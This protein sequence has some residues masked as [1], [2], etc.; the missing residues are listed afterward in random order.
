M[1]IHCSV[2]ECESITHAKGLCSK[3]YQRLK[4]YGNAT[5]TIYAIDVSKACSVE[6]C[7]RERT[8]GKFCEKHYRRYTKTGDPLIGGRAE[9]ADESYERMVVRNDD[10][11][12]CWGW[13]GYLDKNPNGSDSFGY[14]SLHD[15]TNERAH[16]FSYK[17]HKGEIPEGMH[18]LHTCDN[19]PCT[20]PRH[21][22]LGTHQD[23]MEDMKRKG[24]AL[25][26]YPIQ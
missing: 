4:K 8:H 6:A 11:D 12:A 19:Q 5:F 24:R 10:P 3:H 22:F 1:N 15:G 13:L 26:P 17:K 7:D 9:T 16:R 23:N 25:G 14:V 20:N 18:V 2:A 21:L